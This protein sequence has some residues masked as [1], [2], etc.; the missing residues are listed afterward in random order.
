VSASSSNRN[1]STAIIRLSNSTV[2]PTSTSAVIAVVVHQA[3]FG[4]RTRA[5]TTATTTG[6]I[7]NRVPSAR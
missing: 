1:R 4:R 5:A 6:G 7:R 3:R 2:S